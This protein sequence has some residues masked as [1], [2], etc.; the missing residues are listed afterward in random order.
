ME[1]YK[2]YTNAELNLK[3]KALEDK[4]EANKRKVLQLIHEMQELDIDY[5]NAKKEIDKRSKGL[6]R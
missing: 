3:L 1:N 4:Y 2:N 5:S 6:W